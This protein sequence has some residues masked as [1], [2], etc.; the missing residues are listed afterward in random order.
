MAERTGVRVR[1]NMREKDTPWRVTLF[2]LEREE[3]EEVAER[4]GERG[5]EM[6]YTEGGME[7]RE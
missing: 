5:R 7:R 1:E 3:S 4:H 2:V 6:G